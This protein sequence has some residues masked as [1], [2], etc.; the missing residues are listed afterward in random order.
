MTVSSMQWNVVVW[1]TVMAVCMGGVSMGVRP[2]MGAGCYVP[3]KTTATVV[4]SPLPHTYLRAED[5][6]AAFDWRNASLTVGGPTNNYCNRVLTQQLPWVCG[7]CWA[8]AA[9]GALS[10]RYTIAT[11]GALRVALAPQMLLNFNPSLTGGSCMGGSDLDAYSFMHKYGGIVDDTC[12]P[13]Q[14][15]NY[16]SNTFEFADIATEDNIQRHSCRYCSW[17]GV[18]DWVPPDQFNRYGVDEFGQ[19]SGVTNIMAEIVARG[20]VACS[21]Y[22]RDPAFEAYRGGVI[23]VPGNNTETT[24]VIVLVGYGVWTN[25]AT[26]A[27][28]PYWIGRFVCALFLWV[29]LSA[30]RR[31]TR[32]CEHCHV[33]TETVTVRV[34]VK[35]LAVGGSASPEERTRLASNS[36]LVR[37]QRHPE[38]TLS[39]RYVSNLCQSEYRSGGNGGSRGNASSLCALTS[40]AHRTMRNVSRRQ[41]NPT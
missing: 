20:P 41:M 40:T 13:F 12:A 25:P 38:P 15:A 2:V 5:L 18:C 4:R 34:G 26:G 3:P 14:G 23:D 10:D 24:H 1:C 6:P 16:A 37:G 27:E 22:G 8:E 19:V 17:E 28:T 31:L 21:L 32:W 39:A 7:S 29:R 35:V 30:V 36:M 9:T 33:T 11:G